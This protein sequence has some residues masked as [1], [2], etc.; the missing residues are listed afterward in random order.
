[1]AA[2]AVAGLAASANRLARAASLAS[3]LIAASYCG[4]LTTEFSLLRRLL[5]SRSSYNVMA[6]LPDPAAHRLLIVCAHHDA[7]RTGFLFHP[8]VFRALT[9][10]T[11]WRR[12]HLSPLAVPL[13][14]MVTGT[15]AAAVR[16]RRAR[17]GL[18]RSSLLLTGLVNLGFATLMLDIGRSPVTPG[19]NDN[20]SGVAVLL[21]LAETLRRKRP[22]G[23]EVWF[24]STGS[25]EGMLG[26]MRAFEQRFRKDL[27]D[28]HAFV[29]NLELLGSG[30]ITY[31]QG[32]GFLRRVQYHPEALALAGQVTDE[33]GWRKAGPIAVPPFVTDALVVAR[34]AIPAL[35]V[36]SVDEAGRF[37]HYHGMSDT[38]QAIDIGSVRD[39]YVFCR[40]LIDHLAEETPEAGD[41]RM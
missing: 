21:G 33:L 28:R 32:E 27:R 4:E 10:S 11:R 36:I 9:A 29:L 20:A 5:P 3:A 24:V 31:L 16:G 8:T 6:R 15:L 14:A 25:E 22:R 19:A 12:L 35:T 2:A 17:P 26:G 34:L 41:G 39:A 18:A 40:S 7:A 13:V 1:L 38:P 30:R 37:P 23:W